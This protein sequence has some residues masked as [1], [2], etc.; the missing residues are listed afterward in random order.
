[1]SLQIFA[2]PWAAN[3][4]SQWRRYRGGRTEPIRVLDLSTEAEEKL[5][6]TNSNDTDPMWVGNT[7]YFLSDR[8]RTVNL[9]A[10]DASTKQLTQLTHHNDFDIAAASAGSDAIAYEQAGYVHLVDLKTGQSHQVNI[11]AVGDFPWARPQMKNVSSLIGNATI[12]PTGAR[13]AFEA[14]GDIF[15]LASD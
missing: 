15:T 9:Y 5:P 8:D 7:I 13:A 14:R 1:M 12:S 4:S 6:W 2:G 10:Y 3:Q 11:E